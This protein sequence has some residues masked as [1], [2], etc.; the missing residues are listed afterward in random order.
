MVNVVQLKRHTE[1]SNETCLL[2][3]W[4]PL[5]IDYVTVWHDIEAI[6]KISLGKG[7]KTSFRVLDG[8]FPFAKL[9]IPSIDGVEVRIEIRVEVEDGLFVV[10][11][12]GRKKRMG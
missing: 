5:S 1:I 9:G 7:I 4:G 2:N 12:W 10:G 11:H 3:I 8:I 6:C